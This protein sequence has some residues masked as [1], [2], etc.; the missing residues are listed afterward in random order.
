MGRENIL[1]TKKE[2]SNFLRH[3]STCGRFYVVRFVLFV[4]KRVEILFV[5]LTDW[6]G[7]ATGGRRLC[8]GILAGG[9]ISPGGSSSRRDSTELSNRLESTELS[10]RLESTELVDCLRNPVLWPEFWEPGLKK[11][12]MKILSQSQTCRNP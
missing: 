3:C 1:S 8:S 10:N 11:Q 12:K 9:G 6:T 7:L 5:Y 4:F 2:D